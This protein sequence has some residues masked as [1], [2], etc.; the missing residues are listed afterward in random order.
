MPH[1]TT[2]NTTLDE[3]TGHIQ[4]FFGNTSNTREETIAGLERAKDQI[5]LLLETMSDEEGEGGK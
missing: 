3:L 1:N 5:N 2:T 4:S